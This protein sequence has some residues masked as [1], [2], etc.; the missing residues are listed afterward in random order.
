ML[1][2]IFRHD[3]ELF[4]LLFITALGLGVPM[5]IDESIGSGD[6]STFLGDVLIIR[7]GFRPQHEMLFMLRGAAR[8]ARSMRARSHS[9]H[10]GLC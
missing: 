4:A 6:E 10:V 9:L 2:F 1:F 7:G 3:A 8:A 5:G